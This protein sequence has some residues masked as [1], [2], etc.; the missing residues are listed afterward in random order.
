MTGDSGLTMD[1]CYMGM[2]GDAEMEMFNGMCAERPPKEC[3]VPLYV[4]YVFYCGRLCRHLA[5]GPDAATDEEAGGCLEAVIALAHA[6]GVPGIR[7]EG[8]A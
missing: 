7:R 4:L 3:E 8:G 6:L 5:K 2:L 1:V